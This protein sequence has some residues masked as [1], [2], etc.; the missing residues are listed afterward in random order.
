MTNWI[1][2]YVAQV[3]RSLPQSKR[4]DI[5]KEIRSLVEDMLEDRSQAEGRAV[6]EEMTLAVLQEMGEP[7]KVAAG[8]LPEKYL[9]G[10][11]LYPLFMLVL[12]IVLIVMA[13]V[14]LFGLVTY[15]GKE[16]MTPL[17]ALKATGKALL[18]YTGTAMQILGNLVLVF[19]ILQW[20]WPKMKVDLHDEKWNA[21]DLEP[22]ED[23]QRVK[24]FEKLWD[25][26]FALVGLLLFNFYSQY[27]GLYNFADGKWTFTPVL[28]DKFFTYLPWFNLA[29][30]LGILLNII[31]MR[32][33]RWDM[34]T[35]WASIGLGVYHIALCASILV[36]GP[37]QLFSISSLA[38]AGI[39]PETGELLGKLANQGLVAAFGLIIVLEAV[40]IGQT[41]WAMYKK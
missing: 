38:V 15:I 10:P 22:V 25:V 9:I 23:P 16:P 12:R 32:R 3:G 40:K 14:A 34:P 2:R 8:Y 39:P 35:R 26:V 11:R 28:G 33:G 1:D 13:G 21:R 19:A 36:T 29:W 5:E 6:D 7:D 37:K 18:E 17:A 30:V 27:V 31:L 4:S 24:R 20:A 41:V